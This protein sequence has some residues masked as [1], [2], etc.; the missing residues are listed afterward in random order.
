VKG[1]HVHFG[2]GVLWFVAL[3]LAFLMAVGMRYC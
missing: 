1:A 3:G 2:N